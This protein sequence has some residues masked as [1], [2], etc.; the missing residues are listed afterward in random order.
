[1]TP[2][3]KAVV[4]YFNLLI[5]E[6]E[7]GEFEKVHLQTLIKRVCRSRSPQEVTVNEILGVQFNKHEDILKFI[8]KFP[9]GIRIVP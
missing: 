2:E 6:G 7:Y 1:M 5:L 9:N 4:E 3:L 8:L